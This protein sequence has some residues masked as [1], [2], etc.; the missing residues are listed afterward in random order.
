MNEK[1]VKGIEHWVNKNEDV[2]LFLWEKYVDD[3]K[4]KKEQFYLFMV[5]L[6]RLNL[7]LICMLKTDHLVQL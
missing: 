3:T 6:W 1:N 7:L 5:L 4:N 2:K